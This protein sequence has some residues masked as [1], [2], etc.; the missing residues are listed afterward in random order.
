VNQEQGQALNAARG[1]AKRDG[2]SPALLAAVEYAIGNADPFGPDFLADAGDRWEAIADEL[3]KTAVARPRDADKL[4]DL[5]A[6]A[7]TGATIEGPKDALMD[8]PGDF[9]GGVAG[10]VRGG[11]AAVP[12]VLDTSAQ[13]ARLAVPL[14]LV[15]AAWYWLRGRG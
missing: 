4:A 12:E 7:Q 8:A 15:G 1:L 6:I 14:V 13:I 2:W 9:L 10:D 3:A 11:L 5:F